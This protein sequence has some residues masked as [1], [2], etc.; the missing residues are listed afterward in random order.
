MLE[1]SD[2]DQC[3]LLT[4]QNSWYGVQ[5][6]AIQTRLKYH[7]IENMLLYLNE[8]LEKIKNEDDEW[9]KK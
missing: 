9:T 2:E 6:G 8:R 5:A 4:L 7:E 3:V 1:K